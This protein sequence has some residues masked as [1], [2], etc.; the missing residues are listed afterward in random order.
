[1]LSSVQGDGSTL[2]II[3]T[4]VPRELQLALTLGGDPSALPAASDQR[5][6]S[7]WLAGSLG[8][9]RREIAVVTSV[10]AQENLPPNVPDEA[11]NVIAPEVRSLKFRYF[12]PQRG[13]WMD[14]GRTWPDDAMGFD[15]STPIGPPP[16]I[17]IT[18]QIASKTSTRRS[19]DGKRVRT[20]RHVVA[21]PTANGLPQ[22]QTSSSR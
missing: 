21:I 14:D 3:T 18:I 6:V 5:V 4:R 11:S 20:F 10:D 2:N 16:A 8:L 9:A 12:D 22:Q 7:Y 19:D 17:E 13:S 1:M 15:G